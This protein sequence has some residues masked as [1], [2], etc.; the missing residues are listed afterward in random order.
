MIWKYV[1]RGV[2]L[3]IYLVF[4]SATEMPEVQGSDNFKYFRNKIGVVK[5]H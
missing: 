4:K 1:Q 3:K 2:F 5:F